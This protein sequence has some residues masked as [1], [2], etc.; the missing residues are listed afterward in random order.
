MT[1]TVAV[2]GSNVI[3]VNFVGSLLIVDG[4]L[5]ALSSLDKFD[6]FWMLNSVGIVS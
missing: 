3:K 4:I 1:F 2:V 6:P 5:S